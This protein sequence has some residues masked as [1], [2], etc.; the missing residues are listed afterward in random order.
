MKE[1]GIEEYKDFLGNTIREGDIV[2]R[3]IHSSFNFHKVIKITKRGV[4]LSRGHRIAEYQTWWYQDENGRYSRHEQPITREYDVFS[5]SIS[6]ADVENH[7][8]T[9]YVRRNCV[10]L[11]LV[12]NKI[13]NKD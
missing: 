3:A 6:V 8:H 1:V 9:I 10:N 13:Y 11:I 2:V 12:T 4:R 7:T 5:G